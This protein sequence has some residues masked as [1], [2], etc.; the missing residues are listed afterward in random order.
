MT[1]DRQCET[2]DKYEPDAATAAGPELFP[3]FVDPIPD[4]T[5]GAGWEWASREPVKQRHVA[6]LA[7]IRRR[8]FAY[9]GGDGSCVLTVGGGKYWPGIVVMIRMLR[10][11]G[12]TLPVEVWYRGSCER[13]RPADVAGLGPVALI[14]A[15]AMAAERGDRRINSTVTD[16]GG[17]EAKL[18]AITHTRYDTLLYLD[19]DAY[20]VAD[21][22]PLL[23]LA[24]RHETGFVYWQDLANTWK[25]VKWEWVGLVAGVTAPVQGGQLAIHRPAA[26]KEIALTHWLCQHSDYWFHHGFGDQD[27]WRI[28]FAATRRVPLN[29]GPCPHREGTAFVCGH[30]GTDYVVH[31]CNG[32]MFEKRLPGESR[33]WRHFAAVIEA[34]QAAG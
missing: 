5:T 29:L 23:Q 24:K 3:G 11:T 20:T 21:P 27:M 8:K 30:N 25:H 7:D 10:D 34:G 26:W 17:W 33:A 13:V 16:Q 15:D 32:K 12:C 6:A 1:Q 31:R 14:D 4:P 19:A 22:T 9:P 18:Y 2:C 28:A